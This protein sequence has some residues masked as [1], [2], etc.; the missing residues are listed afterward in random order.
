MFLYTWM[1]LSGAQINIPVGHTPSIMFYQQ[2][3]I[4]LS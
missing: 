1:L 3:H 2:E 4:G